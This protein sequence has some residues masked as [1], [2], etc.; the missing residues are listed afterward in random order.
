MAPRYYSKEWVEQ[1]V[2]KAN[3]DEAYLK[4]AAKFNVKTW[5]VITD[6]PDGNDVSVKWTYEN[7]KVANYVYETAP[8]PS[9]FRIGNPN[10][11]ES[12]SLFRTQASYET[13][14]KIQRREVSVMASMNARMYV[15]E[16][17]MMKVLQVLS[18]ITAFADVMSTVPCEY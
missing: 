2:Q 15:T 14:G 6:D 8:A 16:G 1:C 4:K 9:E 11:D 17:D 5:T 13:W 7:G 3:S 12:V 18:Y 10:W